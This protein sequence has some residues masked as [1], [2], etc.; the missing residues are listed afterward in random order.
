MQHHRRQAHGAGLG[1]APHHRPQLVLGIGQARQD[2]AHQPPARHPALAEL[3]AQLQALLRA[4]RP[5]LHRAAQPV[6]DEADGDPG[7]DLGHLGRLGEQLGITKDQRALGHHPEGVAGV[8]QRGHDAGHQP[9]GPLGLLVAVAAQPDAH[10]LARPAGG[11]QL[12]PQPPGGVGLD[13][14]GRA[15]VAL[16]VQPEVAVG[17]AGRAVEAGVGASPV[18]TDRPGDAEPDGRGHPVDDRAR[19]HLV[20]GRVTRCPADRLPLYL[21]PRRGGVLDK[22]KG[23]ETH[24]QQW[25]THSIPVASDLATLGREAGRS[26]GG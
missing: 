1:D 11:G 3:G 22:G 6:V 5:W 9:V 26:A 24:D 13:H 21:R 12:D 25:N 14:D 20:E 15:E 8:A 10:R 7:L 16:A 2:G 23:V 17:A 4:R 19:P 18:G